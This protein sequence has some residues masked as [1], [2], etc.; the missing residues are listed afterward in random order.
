[1][2]RMRPKRST[3]T[4]METKMM[5]PPMVG[6]PFFFSPKGSMDASRC[7]SVNFFFFI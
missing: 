4:M 3:G 5:M 6:T 7:T 1:M 2:L